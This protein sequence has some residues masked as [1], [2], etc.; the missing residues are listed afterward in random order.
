MPQ[1]KK[2]CVLLFSLSCFDLSFCSPRW[3][4]RTIRIMSVTLQ[5]SQIGTRQWSTKAYT[6]SIICELLDG[7]NF[8]YGRWMV[9]RASLLG[10]PTNWKSKLWLCEKYCVDVSPTQ[11]TEDVFVKSPKLIVN[12]YIWNIL[13][14]DLRYAKL[15]NTVPASLISP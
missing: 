15:Q 4:Q 6:K 1:V 3:S 9:K 14:P 2:K 10:P 13:S 11:N 8:V 12:K 5:D 7:C